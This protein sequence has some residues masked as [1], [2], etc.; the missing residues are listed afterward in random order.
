MTAN[1]AYESYA[2]SRYR[3]PQPWQNQDFYLI[4][5]TSGEPIAGLDRSGYLQGISFNCHVKRMMV[6]SAVAEGY[7][8][9]IADFLLFFRDSAHEDLHWGLELMPPPK[10]VHELFESKV[11]LL[12][13][14]SWGAR[15][16]VADTAGR[17][18][19]SIADVWKDTDIARGVHKQYE[20]HEA[21]H[22]LMTQALWAA[23]ALGSG[24]G[25]HSPP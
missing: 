6:E 1:F 9:T 19:V 3:A 11:L 14:I 23:F 12:R 22:P 20:L 4:D 18:L 2:G 17:P 13:L 10:F 24:F 16:A 25:A 15:S 7:A 5:L 8:T 21:N